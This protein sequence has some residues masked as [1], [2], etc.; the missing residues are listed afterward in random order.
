MYDLPLFPLHTVL[1]PGTPLH[2]HIFEERYK[3]MVSLC[4]ENQTPFGVVLIRRGSEALGPLA[5]PYPIGCT[6]QIVQTQRLE[7]G[8]MN[9][10][11][12]GVERFKIVEIDEQALPYLMG[13]VETYPLQQ[14]DPAAVKE[15]GFRLRLWVRRYLGTLSEAGKSQFDPN[16]LPNDP[17]ALAYLAATLVQM[18]AAQKQEILALPSDLELVESL[19]LTYRRET[20]FLN[21]ILTKGD[22]GHGSFSTN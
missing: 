18:P 10:E 12:V 8:R 2:L 15:A 17:V 4:L 1:F 22:R 19:H 20:A 3:R 9:I 16:L 11:A 6:A 7:E 21:T 14:A 13:S 5:E